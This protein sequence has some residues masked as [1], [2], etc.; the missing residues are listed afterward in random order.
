MRGLEYSYIDFLF[1]LRLT[2]VGVRRIDP[3]LKL[4]AI[5]DKSIEEIGAV[6]WPRGVYAQLMEELDRLGVD[7][8]VFDV[9]FSEPNQ[10]R[11]QEDIRLAQVTKRFRNKVIHAFFEDQTPDE[12]GLLTVQVRLPYPALL[13]TGAKTGFVDNSK[14]EGNRTYTSLDRDGTVRRAYLAKQTVTGDYA[15]ALGAQAFAVLKGISIEKFVANFP[16]EISLNYPGIIKRLTQ[17]GKIFV[18]EPYADFSIRDIIKRR[19]SPEKQRELKGAI[20][21]VASTAT[22]Y[23]DHYPTPYYPNSPGVAMH[24]YALDNLLQNNFVRVWPRILSL[25]LTVFLGLLLAFSLERYSGILNAGLL[26]IV[27]LTLFGTSAYL[28]I[29]HSIVFDIL[30]PGICGFL[31]VMTTA[32]YRFAVEEKKK[33][34]LRSTFS[35]YL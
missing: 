20:V 32:I 2:T 23:Y 31:V 25:L 9:I 5:D 35:Q 30:V 4:A 16:H 6:P 18:K 8:M 24:M 29:Y 14:I 21:F 27:I 17:S 33:Q 11:P 15:L 34:S 7:L 1:N 10:V 19:L 13:N 26:I 3:R 12:K 22:G 28:F